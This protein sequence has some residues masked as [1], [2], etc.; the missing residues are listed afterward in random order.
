MRK[1]KDF[2]T[3]E[4]CILEHRIRY[5]AR[6]NINKIGEVTVRRPRAQDKN[7]AK[8]P[9]RHDYTVSMVGLIAVQQ[10]SK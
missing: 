8:R 4:E 9:R 6:N 1:N 10:N 3:A 5:S 2:Q 7:T